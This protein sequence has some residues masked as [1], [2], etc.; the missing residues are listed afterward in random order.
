LTQ[1]WKGLL[2]PC[3]LILAPPALRAAVP[4]VSDNVYR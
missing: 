2:D 1:A 4:N 3:L